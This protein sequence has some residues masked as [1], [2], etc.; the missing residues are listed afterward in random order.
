MR[1]NDERIKANRIRVCRAGHELAAVTIVLEGTFV[2]HQLFVAVTWFP[3]GV[4]VT[5][6]SIIARGIVCCTVPRKTA[7][8]DHYR[9]NGGA[10][11]GKE[12]AAVAGRAVPRDRYL[13]QR[14]A[15]TKH[16]FTMPPPPALLEAAPSFPEDL[17]LIT[18]PPSISSVAW[19]LIPPP[20]PP[21][22][23][24]RWSRREY[25]SAA[26]CAGRGGTF[27][28]PPGDPVLVCV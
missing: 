22:C 6:T 19:L 10:T 23:F 4:A 24:L 5:F 2:P 27:R 9:A 25:G 28:R 1:K 21:T 16:W 26:A 18:L 14:H 12:S 3:A 17:L 20:F 8:V 11:A 7:E 13:A 15:V